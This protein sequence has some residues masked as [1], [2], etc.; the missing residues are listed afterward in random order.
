M[1]LSLGRRHLSLQ[2][3][4]TTAAQKTFRLSE[5]PVEKLTQAE[6]AACREAEEAHKIEK[7]DKKG[8]KY[9][10]SYKANRNR[11][12]V[13]PTEARSLDAALDLLS[14]GSKELEKHPERRA[15]AAYKAFEAVMLP[16]L[17]EDYPGLKLSQYNQNLKSCKMSSTLN[18]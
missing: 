3:R 4:K 6:I 1:S 11:D 2:P 16:H 17:K 18:N 9:D 13:E 15:K 14:V 10:N 7:V 8:I 12:Q 5:T